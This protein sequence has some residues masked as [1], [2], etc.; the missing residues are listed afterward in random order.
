MTIEPVLERALRSHQTPDHVLVA[1]HCCN[2]LRNLSCKTNQTKQSMGLLEILQAKALLLGILVTG[3]FGQNEKPFYDTP[4]FSRTADH[5]TNVCE[6][7]EQLV[8]DEI[9]LPD[10][11]RGLSLSVILTDYDNDLNKELFHL[12]SK[13]GG[14]PDGARG[15]PLFAQVMDELA[16]RAGFTWR[17]SYAA[18]KPLSKDTDGNNTWSDLLKW[19]VETFDIAMGRWDRTSQRIADEISFPEGWYDSSI[20]LVQTRDGGDKDLNIWSFM[21]PFKTSVWFLIFATLVVSGWVYYLLERL[22]HSADLQQLESEP[23]SAMYYSFITFTGKFSACVPTIAKI[24]EN[25][26]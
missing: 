23:G 20:I 21:L 1:V 18:V 4:K 3:S 10:A 26:C 14:I 12:D 24:S 13:T 8:R 5:R 9:D 7:H 6:R 16:E 19:E 2:R 11:L 25:C 22:D 15:A 17:N